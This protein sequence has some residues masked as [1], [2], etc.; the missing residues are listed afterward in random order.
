MGSKEGLMASPGPGRVSLVVA[1]LV[2]CPV[3]CSVGLSPQAVR[4][5]RHLREKTPNVLDPRAVFGFGTT[6]IVPPKYCRNPSL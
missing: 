1:C 6:A 5:R 3:V 4:R 2:A